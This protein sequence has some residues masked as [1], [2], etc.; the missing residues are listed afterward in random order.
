M[1]EENTNVEEVKGD[2]TVPVADTTEVAAVNETA[3]S[4]EVLDI[5][6]ST[7]AEDIVPAVVEEV[8]AESEVK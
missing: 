2:V 4:E 5:T 6:P 1:Q 3:V 7:V 8:V